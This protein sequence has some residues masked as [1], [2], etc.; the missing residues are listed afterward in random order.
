MYLHS[1]LNKSLLV[2]YLIL[3]KNYFVRTFESI[4][5]ATICEFSRGHINSSQSNLLYNKKW[6]TV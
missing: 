1:G 6:D 2:Y 3:Q 5:S 4:E